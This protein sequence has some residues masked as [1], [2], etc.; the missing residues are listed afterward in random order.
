MTKNI[1]KICHFVITAAADVK[2]NTT[3]RARKNKINT[4][5][6]QTEG[7]GVKAI[8]VNSRAVSFVW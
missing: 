8:E 3:N 4:E 5:I 2:K 1:K 6:S 7:K